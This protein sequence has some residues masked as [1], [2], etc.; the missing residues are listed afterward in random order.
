[1]PGG[2]T[3]QG[4]VLVA[5]RGNLMGD[6]H[7]SASDGSRQETVLAILGAALLV[8]IILMIFAVTLILH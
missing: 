4:T 8:A 3:R 2:G 6:A 5:E 7:P 1:M